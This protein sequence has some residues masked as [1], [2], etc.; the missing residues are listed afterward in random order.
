M[1]PQ[2]SFLSHVSVNLYKKEFHNN[3]ELSVL[4]CMITDIRTLLC[5]V[6]HNVRRKILNYVIFSIENTVIIK[7]GI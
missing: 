1:Y 2:A 3:Y 5:I 7:I 4:D 6:L